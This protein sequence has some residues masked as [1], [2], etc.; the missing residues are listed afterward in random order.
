M[1]AFLS[2]IFEFNSTNKENR[3]IIHH[4]LVSP[5]FTTVMELK[6]LKENNKLLMTVQGFNRTV[7]FLLIFQDRQINE[8]KN[9]HDLWPI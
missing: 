8:M 7:G 6:Y 2:T 4:Q 1:N 5:S 9:A 3:K